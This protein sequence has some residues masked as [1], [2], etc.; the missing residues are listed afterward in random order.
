MVK[1]TQKIADKLFECVW[2]FCEIGAKRVKVFML[3][4]F[5]VRF[6]YDV[7]AI[8]I[9]KLRWLKLNQSYWILTKKLGSSKHVNYFSSWYLSR[10]IT[11]TKTPFYSA[12]P[13]V[14]T[15]WI[16]KP[17]KFAVTIVS[18]PW[19]IPECLFCEIDLWFP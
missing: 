12:T 4:G 10:E 13:C 11:I 17:Q 2:P 5:L 7:F 15:P 8:K 1:H 19:R 9:L 14:D 18:I 3:G 16:N 6:S